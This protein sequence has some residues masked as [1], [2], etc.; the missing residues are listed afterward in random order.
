MISSAS[1]RDHPLRAYTSEEAAVILGCEPGWLEELARQRKV[2]YTELSGTCHFTNAHLAAITLKFEVAPADEPSE[3]AA[4]LAPAELAHDADRAAALIGGTCKASWLKQQ[5]RDG[6][7]PYVKL[8]GAYN[9]TDADL[10]EIMTIF[11]VGPRTQSA[12]QPTARPP[13]PV[14]T[15]PGGQ[16][17]PL[18]ESRTPR[19]RRGRPADDDDPGIT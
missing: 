17:V 10:A 6:V 9:F 12:S 1:Y 16:G 7:I 18:L 8:G 19:T 2:R 15:A 3:T 11:G 13:V 5:A 14:V 4:S